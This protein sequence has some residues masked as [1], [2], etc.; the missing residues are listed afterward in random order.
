MDLLPNF[1]V[2]CQFVP[3]IAE[4]E[5]L[6]N[7]TLHAVPRRET[8]FWDCTVELGINKSL[9]KLKNVT[10]LDLV[11]HLKNHFAVWEATQ[12]KSD[13]PLLPKV[14]FSFELAGKSEQMRAAPKNFIG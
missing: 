2:S 8:L 5:T 1:N 13:P 4:L 9:L 14:C 10:F 12:W 11:L 6:I 7:A 3:S